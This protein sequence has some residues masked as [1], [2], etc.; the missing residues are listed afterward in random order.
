MTS[1]PRARCNKNFDENRTIR[2]HAIKYNAQ[3]NAFSDPSEW[4]STSTGPAN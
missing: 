4:E 2:F 3:N 1:G